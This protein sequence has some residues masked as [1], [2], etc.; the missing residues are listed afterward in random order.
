MHYLSKIFTASKPETTQADKVED[1]LEK[2]MPEAMQ[3]EMFCFTMRN[4]ELHQIKP[5]QT[6]KGAIKQTKECVFMKASIHITSMLIDEDEALGTKINIPL[7]VIS[8]DRY[9]ED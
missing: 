3:E 5:R 1:V 6:T 9:E 8:N 7:V 2:L 4:C